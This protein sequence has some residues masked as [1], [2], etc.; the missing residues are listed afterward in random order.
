MRYAVTGGAG[1]IGSH[2]AEDLV[3]KGH[4]VLVLDNLLSGKLENIAHL[5]DRENF[6]FIQGS[7][8]D[9][10]LLKDLFSDVDG[11]FHEAAIA[12]VPFSVRDPLAT[13][14]V[15]VTGTLH[16]AVAA[17]DCGVKKIV[18][19]SSSAIYGDDP[20]FPKREDM[21][22]KPISPY[23][24]SKLAGEYYLSNFSDLYGLK[25]VSLRYF[26][27]FGPR[28]DPN[29]EYAA[30]IPKFITRIL[31]HQSPHIYGD[32]TQTRDFA[33]VKDV[34]QANV[35]AMEHDAGGVFNIAYGQRVNLKELAAMMREITGIPIPVLHE[36]PRQGDIRD[37]FAAI[38]RARSGFGYEPAYTVK[39]GL[40]ETIRWYRN[41]IKENPET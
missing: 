2:I 35:K 36:P 18:F 24:V 4:E 40:D 25:T 30:V 29:S 37:S 20:T 9:L 3:K 34:V 41:M 19:A 32:G 11:I 27:I 1:F 5:V 26:N 28:Q 8:T 39:K 6:I 14:E 22:P 21:T 31:H 13:N 17:R 15:N 7:I 33:Y 23:A 38:E 10:P 12:S 16:V